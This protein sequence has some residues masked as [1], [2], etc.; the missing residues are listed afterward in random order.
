MEK[1]KGE[2][3]QKSGKTQANRP[4]KQSHVT[5]CGNKRTVYHQINNYIATLFLPQ[6]ISA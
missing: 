4:Q 3:M 1:Q 6:F 2:R 5:L